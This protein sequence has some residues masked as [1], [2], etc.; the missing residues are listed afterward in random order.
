MPKHFH[1][2]IHK[3]DV[4]MKEST[5]KNVYICFYTLYDLEST[6]IEIR[7]C[8]QSKPKLFLVCLSTKSAKASI[9]LFALFI[10]FLKRS[11]ILCLSS[12]EKVF[13]L[14]YYAILYFI[15]KKEVFSLV[16]I[17]TFA[18]FVGLLKQTWDLIENSNN[19]KKKKYSI[20]LFQRKK[21]AHSWCAG[22]S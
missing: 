1:P 7:L 3:L 10:T 18:R 21:I 8:S 13:W 12:S 6:V 16:I 14:W 2:K 5:P 15:K 4:L 22:C 19:S 11:V 20:S 9:L 17:H